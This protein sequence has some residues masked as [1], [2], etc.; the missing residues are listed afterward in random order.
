MR[1]FQS[2]QSS[3]TAAVIVVRKN[4]DERLISSRWGIFVLT[5]ATSSKWLMWQPIRKAVGAMR[6]SSIPLAKT[7]TYGCCHNRGWR[8]QETTGYKAPRRE[9]EITGS[10]VRHWPAGRAANSQ[11]PAWVWPSQKRRTPTSALEGGRTVPEERTGFASKLK[12]W[13][14]WSYD[15]SHLQQCR[16]AKTE[17]RQVQVEVNNRPVL[18]LP[19][20]KNY[21]KGTQVET[22]QHRSNA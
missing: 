20:W 12:F 14:V 6:K 22:L 9:A 11:R 4:D 21:L 7:G 19:W 3:E 16:M 15:V 5:A 8:R 17:E 18:V 10:K 13:L 1:I 2:L